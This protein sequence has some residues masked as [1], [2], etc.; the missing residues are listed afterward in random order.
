M[1]HV[2]KG[3]EV[4][5]GQSDALD[6]DA[7]SKDY[8][9]S[10]RLHVKQPCIESRMMR[11]A[12]WQSVSPVIR[13]RMGLAPDVRRYNQLR[14]G[15]WA[16]SALASVS[17]KHVEAKLLLTCT[18]FHSTKTTFGNVSESEGIAFIGSGRVRRLRDAEQ[19]QELP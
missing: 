17:F 1:W 9:M 2:P 4:I 10:F 8:L 13:A 19:D 14:V 5:G 11:V 18:H 6:R 12:Q 3:R 16:D 15:D 7:R